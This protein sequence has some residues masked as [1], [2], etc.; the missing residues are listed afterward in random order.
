MNLLQQEQSAD[1]LGDKEI[2]LS[3]VIALFVEHRLL[4]ALTTVVV[5]LLGVAYA[6]IGTPMYKA[7]VMI[8][9]DSDAGSDT[10]N[11]KR[12][13]LAS[14]FQNKAATDAEIQLIRSRMVVEETVRSL[15]LELTFRRSRTQFG[16]NFVASLVG[17]MRP[18]AAGLHEQLAPKIRLW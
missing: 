1:T 8:Q 11:D 4:I 5:L 14:L 9:V 3:E 6:F 18:R 17:E 16:V 10:L 13:D 15:H 12:G 7:D 2:S